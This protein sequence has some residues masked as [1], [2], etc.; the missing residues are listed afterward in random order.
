M[1]IK[2]MKSSI[3]SLLH[4]IYQLLLKEKLVSPSIIVRMDGG[5]CSQM[6]QYL[7]GEIFRR[8]GINVEYELSF[9]KKDGKDVNGIHVRNFDLLKM[10]PYLDFKAASFMKVKLYSLIYNYIG[11]YPDDLSVSWVDLLPPH[12]LSGYYADPPYL[13]Y[14]LYKEVF[15]VS[16]VGKMDSKNQC[17]YDSIESNNSVAI[18]VRRGD[19]SD[20]NIAYGYP[21]T[22]HYFVKAIK[23]MQEK[24]LA[25]TFYFFSDD[26]EYVEQELLP[27]IPFVIKSIIIENG[28]DKGFI[29]LL[30]IS[31]CAH[32]ITSKGSLGKHGA[33]LSMNEDK[34]VIVS[35]DDTQTF[36]FDNAPCSKIII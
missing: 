34:I 5:I 29:D 4:A 11:N 19:L 23:I 25:P 26:K 31:K 14:P 32:Q 20:Y 7:L 35:K 28:P 15:N 1:V 36:M 8:K 30:L 33:L 21:V 3:K 2:N 18:H 9:F 24:V 16:Q 6:H 27:A 17:I 12:I 13:Y 22:I 10:F